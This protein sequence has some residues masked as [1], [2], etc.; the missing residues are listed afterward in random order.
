MKNL[1]P[2]EKTYKRISTRCKYK[3]SSTYEYYKNIKIEI[4]TK[5]LKELWFRDKA[6]LMDKP[7]IDRINSKDNYTKKNCRYIEL[8]KNIGRETQKPC[9]QLTLEGKFIRTYISQSEASRQTGTRRRGISMCVLG[10]QYTS[11]GYKWRNAV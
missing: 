5:D 7:S 11:G 9:K 1:R 3:K 10:K 8:F 2:W 4:T 6:Y